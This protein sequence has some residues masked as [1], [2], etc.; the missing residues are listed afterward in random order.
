MKIESFELSDL[1]SDHKSI[2]PYGLVVMSAIAKNILQPLVDH[3]GVNIKVVSF[4]EAF[5][6][7]PVFNSVK[8]KAGQAKS[9]LL[10]RR[11]TNNDIVK[12]LIKNDI[13]DQ[14]ELIGGTKLNP[15]MIRISHVSQISNR[16]E[17]LFSPTGKPTKVIPKIEKNNFLIIK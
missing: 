1:S 6:G 14:L 8:I 16:K 15:D 10:D 12:F 11:L 9:K 2:T 17:M 13:Y 3:F 4:H 7:K 5:R